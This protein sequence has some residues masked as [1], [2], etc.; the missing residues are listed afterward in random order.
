MIKQSNDTEDPKEVRKRLEELIKESLGASGITIPIKS[1]KFSSGNAENSSSDQST[2]ESFDFNFDHKPRDVKKYLDRFVIGQQQAK[3]VLSI[4]ICDHYN[5]VSMVQQSRG[6]KHYLKQNILILGP[7]GVGKT[8]LIRCLADLIGVPFV[9]A[10]A[11]K[12]SETGYVGQDV[13]D[14]VR[15][16]VQQAD[17]N[18]AKAECGIIYLDEVDKLASVGSF[19]GR[20]VSGRGVQT[21]LLKLMEETEVPL[22]ATNDMQGQMEAAFEAMQGKKSKTKTINTRS[23]LFIA[24]GSFPKLR[25][26]IERRVRAGAMGFQPGGTIEQENGEDFNQLTTKDLIEYGFEAEFAGR[27]PVRVACLPLKPSDLESILEQSEGSILTQYKSAFDA[28]NIKLSFT[29]D[30]IKHIAQKAFR[31]GNWC[32]SSIICS[33]K[34]TTRAKIRITFNQAI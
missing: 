31:R 8:Y 32:Q 9:K 3:R 24:S 18:V 1:T 30:A 22:R 20:D 25:E 27:L 19:S 11:T 17:G 29:D 13:D 28:Y 26:M 5:H 33:R 15:Q 6:I 4:A 14:L 23:I 12:F 7:T 16:L 34:T 21:N 2:K 10:D